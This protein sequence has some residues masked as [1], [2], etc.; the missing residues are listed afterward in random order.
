MIEDL[1]MRELFRIESGEHLQRLEDGLLR[2]E[3]EPGDAAILEE[4]FREAHSL[5]GA[6]KMLGLA[7]TEA[8]AHRFEDLLGGAKSGKSPLTPQ[9][10]DAMYRCLDSIAK[11][12]EEACTGKASGVE[13]AELLSLLNRDKDD[14]KKKKEKEKEKKKKEEETESDGEVEGHPQKESAAQPHGEEPPHPGTP[15]PPPP[16]RHEPFRIDTIRVETRKLDMLMTHAGELT[17][18]KLRVARR[19][20]DMEE[21]LDRWERIAS[22]LRGKGEH[23]LELWAGEFSPL[24]DRVK[25]AVSD[26]SSRLES[27]AGAVEEAILEVRL[28]PLSTIFNTLPRMVRDLSLER[29]KSVR[30]VIEGGETSA[31]KRVLEEMK[32]PLMH[33]VRNAVD[34]GIEPPE[35]RERLGKPQIGTILLRA[36]RTAENVVVEV[37]DDGR[38]LDADAIRRAARKCGSRREEELAGMSPDQVRGLVFDSG[39]STSPFISDLSGRGVGLDVVRTNVERLKGGVTVESTPGAGCTLRVTLPLTLAT[40]RVLIVAARGVNYALPVEY[41]RKSYQL[42][43]STIFSIEGRDAVNFEGETVAVARL[44][45]LLKFRRTDFLPEQEAP[46]GNEERRGETRFPCLIISTGGGRLFGLLVD[47]LLDEQE[48]VLKP[49]SP[50]LKHVPGIS[51]ATILGTGEVCMIL[52]PP[53]LARALRQEVASPT[54]VTAAAEQERKKTVLVAED[55]LTT[56]TQMKR[57]LEGVGYEVATA[58]DGLD[59]LSKLGSRSFD[60]LVSDISMPNMDGLTLTRKVRQH[61]KYGE[62]P[63]VLVTMLSSDED[64][65]RG[66]EAGA[67]AYITKPA[68]EQKLLLETLRRLT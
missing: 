24:L 15:P 36:Y 8:I 65:R 12:A 13:V 1:E 19:C 50:L 38:G 25:R 18:A 63:I 21:L 31:D 17:V 11:L 59:A 27:V 56:R 55:S 45:D 10:I 58:V 20:A 2:L 51:G 26:D 3:K 4:L 39:L 64:K 7:A 30:M 5:K 41:V 60:A 62:L 42:A 29:S 68:F 33:I 28:L 22:A 52:N 44:S 35:E 47:E 46:A 43:G 14:E 57:I 16:A 37:Q 34:H 6:S 48:I 54:R 32:A 53:E 66:M 67:N 40:G 61:K 9:A 23:E 49:Q